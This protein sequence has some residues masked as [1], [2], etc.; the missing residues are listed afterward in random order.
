MK[1]L[2]LVAFVGVSSCSLLMTVIAPTY[3]K[4]ILLGMLGPLA[5]GLGT[6]ITMEQALGK[7]PTSMT[8]RMIRGFSLKMLF[9]PIYVWIAII[10]LEVNPVAFALSFT[11]YFV[12]LQISEAFY[13]KTLTTQAI[14]RSVN[15]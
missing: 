6:I 1:L 8:G 11:G 4:A 2:L 14:T 12:S 13:L 7:D 15:H 9:Y 3:A 5:T 10:G